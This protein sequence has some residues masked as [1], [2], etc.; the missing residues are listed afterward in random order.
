M[1]LPNMLFVLSFALVFYVVG[2]SFMEAFVNYRT[3]P[4]IGEATFQRYHREVSQRVFAFV[5]VPYLVSLISTC[6]LLWWRPA[7]I[8][9]WTVWFSLALNLNVVLVSAASQIPIQLE[10]DRSGWSAPQLAKLNRREW[11]RKVPLM[12]NAIL[13]LWMMMHTVTKL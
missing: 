1:N 6:G 2:A 7:A 10:F 12:G 4:L 3:W 11:L 13:F 8:P 9:V 5:V